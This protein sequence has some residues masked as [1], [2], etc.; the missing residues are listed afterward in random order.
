VVL[1]AGQYDLVTGYDGGNIT[2]I[3]EYN[4]LSFPLKTKGFED[5]TAYYFRFMT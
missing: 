2:S 3:L 5:I 1:L 4:W